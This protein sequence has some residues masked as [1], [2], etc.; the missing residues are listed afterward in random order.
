M[1]VRVRHFVVLGHLACSVAWVAVSLSLKIQDGPIVSVLNVASLPWWPL[2]AIYGFG[3]FGWFLVG[4]A[5]LA[6]FY[7]LFIE[8]VVYLFSRQKKAEDVRS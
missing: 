8:L 1:K 4:S 7:I 5:L 2:V 3:G 6:A